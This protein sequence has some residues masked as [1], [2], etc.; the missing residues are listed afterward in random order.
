MRISGLTLK[1]NLFLA[2]M[3]GITGLPFRI[4]AR[5]FGCALAFTEMASAAGL[6][7]G[8]GKSR[9]YLDSSE[10]DRPLGVQIFGHNP[11]LLAEAAQIAADGGA[12]L[13]DINMGCPAKKVVKAGAGAALLKDPLHISRII[14]A[15]RKTISL[16]LTV[17]I[18]SGWS[19]R[20]INAAEIARIAE[21]CGADAVIVHPRTAEQGFGGKADWQI[22]KA[23]KEN[24][25]VPVIGNGDIIGPADALRMLQLTG[26]DGVMIGRG[27]LG[28][29]WLI[30]GILSLLAGRGVPPPTSLSDRET[31]IKRHLD[32]EVDY[33]GEVVGSRNFRKHLLWYS[34]GLPGSAKFR[35]FLPVLRDKEGILRELHNFFR[36]LKEGGGEDLLKICP[37][38][39]K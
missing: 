31:A 9:R 24:L 34:K 33:F 20:G 32:M 5:Q 12:D 21:D 27:A 29:P 17:K 4:M 22:I 30:S 1:N 6:V 14:I 38:P 36:F 7:R 3:A 16:P 23:V 19:H 39:P 26:C 11:A 25:R 10:E 13:L 8:M 28:N 2:P 35:G 15:V 18:R 37:V